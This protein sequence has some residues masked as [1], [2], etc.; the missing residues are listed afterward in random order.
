MQIR[1]LTR[2]E[3]V[4]GQVKLASGFL[5]RFV[6]LMGRGRLDEDGGLYLAPCNGIHMFFMRFAID[7]IWLGRRNPEGS[8][9]VLRLD[10]ALRPW[11][12]LVPLVRGAAGVI[13]LPVGAIERSGTTVGDLLSL[14]SD[15]G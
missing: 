9:Q 7:A 15:L 13:E 8:Y 2:A 11:V 6:G 14:D 4:A 3:P 12:G 5:D 10:R 1:N